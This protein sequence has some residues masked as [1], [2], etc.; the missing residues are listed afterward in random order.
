MVKVVLARGF[1]IAFLLLST[2][3][4]VPHVLQIWQLEKHGHSQIAA[5]LVGEGGAVPLFLGL[6]EAAVLW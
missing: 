5:F 6:E 3:P 2:V 1:S 4:S